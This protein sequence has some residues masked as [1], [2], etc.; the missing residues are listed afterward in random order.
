M[1][2]LIRDLL[3]LSRIRKS[4]TATG[5][6]DPRSVLL[7]VEAE[8]KLRLEETGVQLELPEDPPLVRA[9]GTRLYQMFSNLIGNALTHGFDGD[10]TPTGARNGKRVSIEVKDHGDEHEII[11]S[12]NGR[13]IAPED[14]ERIFEAFKTGRGVRRGEQSHGIG[15][16]IVKKIAHAHGGRTWVE[17]EPGNGAHF[18]VVLPTG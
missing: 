17:S 18:H 12:D 8:L 9:D 16:A 10:T 3:E 14:H 13:G 1:D 4:E 7:Q 6:L 2:G 15:L 11:V 5:L